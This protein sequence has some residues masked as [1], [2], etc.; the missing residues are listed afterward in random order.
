VRSAKP[1]NPLTDRSE[2]GPAGS[3]MFVNIADLTSGPLVRT[4]RFSLPHTELLSECVEQWPPIL[5]RLSDHIVV[6]GHHRVEAARQLGLTRL[7]A[8]PYEGS[9]SEAYIEAV[10]RNIV[11]GRAL[12]LTER[13]IAAKRI[14]SANIG[15]SDRKVAGLCGLASGTVGK[16]RK[17]LAAGPSGGTTAAPVAQL[18][19]VEQCRDKSKHA[20]PRMPQ[21]LGKERAEL[22]SG[23]KWNAVV[24][25]EDGTSPK[26]AT[27][28][29]PRWFSSKA[30]DAEMIETHLAAV[31]L[32]RIYEIADE[33]R[34]RSRFWVGF[35]D[36]ID[37]GR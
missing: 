37:R 14:L 2:S 9:D 13:K 20:P 18:F 29:F 19:K 12:T 30:I 7:A 35:A 15:F 28:E 17:E 25:H 4:R 5:V 21:P 26:G 32:S 6:D 36:A 8:E 16:I 11:H 34:R 22:P 10:S 33:A 3:V 24:A 23:R 27:P 31:P 1:V